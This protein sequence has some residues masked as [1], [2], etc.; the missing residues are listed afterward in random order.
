MVLNNFIQHATL[1]GLVTLLT[2][3]GCSIYI[4]ALARELRLRYRKANLSG[5]WLLAQLRFLLF[6]SSQSPTLAR[7][8][9]VKQDKPIATILSELLVPK[10]PTI[11]KVDYLLSGLIERERGKLEQG[12]SNLGTIAVIAPF[13]GLFGT[14]I[15][16]TK[17]FADV[18]KVGK[19]GIEIVS[20]GVSEA[21][22]TTAVG[23]VV[24]I[25][26]VVLFNT[27]KAKFEVLVSDW[28]STGRAFISLIT[29]PPEE[30]KQMF[31]LALKD[32]PLL[33]AHD[34]VKDSSS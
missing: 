17:T 15:G 1:A 14:V 11:E 12:L 6:N 30:A 8:F 28:D 3:L 16:I 25:T 22:V 7:S 10:Q 27:F 32:E 21:L 23:L 26:S 2:L 33:A 9:L 19:T 24:A 5:Y 34:F 13:I 4:V 18:A 31:E 20:A 29:S